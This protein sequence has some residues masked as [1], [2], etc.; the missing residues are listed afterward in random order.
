MSQVEKGEHRRSYEYERCEIH[1]CCN[2]A[3]ATVVLL[4]YCANALEIQTECELELSLVVFRIVR[5]H[6]TL[7]RTHT[8]E[9]FVAVTKRRL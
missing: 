3:A 4:L 7:T 1:W 6:S 5:P 8:E 2:A 9:P